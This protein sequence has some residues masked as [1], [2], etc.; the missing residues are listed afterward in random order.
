MEQIHNGLETGSFNRPD[1]IVSMEVC[2]QSGKLA[3]EGL[4]DSDPRGAQLKTEYF[5]R[6]SYCKK[7]YRRR[8]TLYNMGPGLCNNRGGTLKGLYQT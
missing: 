4:C 7:S 2:A 8:D 6:S 5:S 1:D 3:V